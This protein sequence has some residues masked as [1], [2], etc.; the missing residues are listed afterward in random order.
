MKIGVT[1]RGDAGLDL[2]WEKKLDTVD[3]AILITKSVNERFRNAVLAASKP[4]IVHANITGLG[5]TFIEPHVAPYEVEVANLCKLIKA[6]FPLE[7]TVLR[8]DPIVPTESGLNKVAKVLAKVAVRPELNC[9][10]GLRIRVSV[11]DEY[12]HVKKRLHDIHKYSFYPGDNFQASD[13]QMHDIASEL[14]FWHKEYGFNFETCAEDQLLGEGIEHVGCVSKRD[15]DILGLK[16]P[17][18][19]RTNPQGRFGCHCL[20]CKTELLE[21]KRQCPHGC[22]YCYWRPVS[23]LR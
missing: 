16:M 5:C 10:Q 12:Q 13:K 7:R 18:N 9:G 21:N 8:I 1:E 15:L 4:V 19:Y 2:S 3:G 17:D 14:E 6:G 11:L 23:H 20:S 22:I